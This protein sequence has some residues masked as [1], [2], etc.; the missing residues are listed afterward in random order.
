M[1]IT[2][3]SQRDTKWASQKLG[4]GTGTIGSYGCL[5]TA[6]AIGI[7]SQGANLGV[8]EVNDKLKSVNGFVGDTK[9]L[10]VWSALPKAF[11]QIKSNGIPEAYNND[12]AIGMLNKGIPVIVEV[13][14]TPIGAPS[15]WILLIGGGKMCDP[16][17]GKIE[18]TSKYAI[19]KLVRWEMQTVAQPTNDLQACLNAHKKAVDDYNVLNKEFEAKKL[20]LA[21]TEKRLIQEKDQAIK[22]KEI[23]IRNLQTKLSDNK[24]ELSSC[25]TNLESANSNY[26]VYM[27]KATDLQN[28][29]DDLERKLK[30]ASDSLEEADKKLAEV[31]DNRQK[32]IEV[33][34]ALS[35]SEK[36]V[37]SETK[38]YEDTKELLNL[39]NKKIEKDYIP[40][41]KQPILRAIQMA[42]STTDHW[43]SLKE[44]NDKKL[45][46][47]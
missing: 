1:N 27:K 28:K 42:I 22:D 23:T 47:K 2:P 20:E 16:W 40:S 6:V 37:K 39:L 43:I 41:V 46:S 4:F 30:T 24:V 26:K 8:G 44:A 7:N 31:S 9:N 25:G 35:K 18:A 45:A 10:L 14:G 32:L 13:D 17:T 19:R 21:E 29:V 34:E 3:L 38:K 5:I 11:P 36:R 15:H 12:V 33:E